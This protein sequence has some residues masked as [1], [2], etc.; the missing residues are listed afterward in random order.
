M[1][2]KEWKTELEALVQNFTVI[3]EG[4]GFTIVE[5]ATWWDALQ[6]VHILSR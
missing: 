3:T 2:A 5:E 1:Q 6:A 4:D